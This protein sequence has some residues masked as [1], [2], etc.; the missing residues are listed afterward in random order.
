[1]SNAKYSL[2]SIKSTTLQ[3]HL[4]ANFDVFTVYG[5]SYEF[6]DEFKMSVQLFCTCRRHMIVVELILQS[7][8]YS[9]LGNAL[10]L[11]SCSLK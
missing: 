6:D 3:R 8:I 11:C 4:D 5:N 1:M 7:F 9:C 10:C 2:S